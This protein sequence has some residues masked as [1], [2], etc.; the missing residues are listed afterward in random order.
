MYVRADWVLGLAG[1]LGGMRWMQRG[2]LCGDGSRWRGE[3]P[4]PCVQS[5]V[6]NTSSTPR[7]TGPGGQW[8]NGFST[9]PPAGTPTMGW[10]RW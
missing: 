10:T 2:S 3:A 4:G 5:A 1:S 8:I 7:S 9:R 6:L